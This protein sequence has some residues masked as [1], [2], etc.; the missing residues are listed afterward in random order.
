MRIEHSREGQVN[1]GS[2]YLIENAGPGQNLECPR[3]ER[4]RL[5]L[6]VGLALA[7][8]DARTNAV[9]GQLNRRE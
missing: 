9:V 8:D 7:L 1:R 6:T 4:R 2:E 3:L 5:R